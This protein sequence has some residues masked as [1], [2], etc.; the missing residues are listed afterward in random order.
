MAW[1]YD[2]K[3]LAAAIAAAAPAANPT[4][5]AV[6]TDT[7]TLQKGDVFFA[8]SGENF[9]G[10]AFVS[11]A[12]ATGAAGA[13]TTR[14]ADEGSCLVVSDPQRA[15]QDFAGYHRDQL[16]ATVLAITG[17]CGKTSSKDLIAAVL[18]S[19]YNVVKTE[20][21][22]NNEIGCPL[23]ILR[24][25]ADTEF[26]VIE[27]GANHV[28]EIAQLCAIARPHESAITMIGPAHLE[29][30]GSIENVAK[31]KGEIAE[32]LPS[33]GT[34]YVN[35]D[36]ARCRAIAD[37]ISCRKIYFGSSGDVVLRDCLP[38]ERG[39]ALAID[40]IGR[41][42][43]PI[44][45]RAHVPNVLL[46]I[47]VGLE[48]GVSEFEGTLREACDKSIRF[49]VFDLGFL[50]II[51]DSYN[52][53]PASV[54]AALDA[55]AEQP[56]NGARIVALG[57]MLELGPGASQLHRAVGEHAARAGVTHLFARGEFAGDIVDAAKNTAG[58]HAEVI[59]AHGDIARRIYEIGKT[60]DVLLVK[61]SRGMR[62]ERVIEALRPLMN[63]T[64]DTEGPVE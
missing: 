6:S 51:D 58:V 32:A 59:E 18:A 43:L 41:V 57:D 37:A 12:F 15:L 30:F 35:A 38:D 40:P 17:S 47:A 8:L 16:N 49:K 11:D 44:Q 19:K 5:S 28:G 13:V 21:N 63:G 52:A 14:P 27:L 26:A 10:N 34:F 53:N 31:A 48:H 55:L 60:G 20:G 4:F 46:A 29:G 33:D 9:D 42:F 61:G 56:C 50:R 39:M 22:L 64:H 1:T 24:C 23:S 3:T 7:R 45:A 2:L 36:D 62:M 54:A 25:G